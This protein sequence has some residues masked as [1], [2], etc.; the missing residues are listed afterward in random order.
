MGMISEYFT[1]KV[2]DGLENKAIW[3]RLEIFAFG[4]IVHEDL[5]DEQRCMTA[6]EGNADAPEDHS[7]A[8][9]TSPA[10]GRAEIPE[11]G[12]A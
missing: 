5:Q 2:L 7:G 4:R 3:E 11:S 8:A 12:R 6:A 1:Q 10:D 9:E